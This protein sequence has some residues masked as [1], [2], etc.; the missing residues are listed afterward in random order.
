MARIVSGVFMF[1]IETGCW[2]ERMTHSTFFLVNVTFS[3]V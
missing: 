2:D 1:P 3:V